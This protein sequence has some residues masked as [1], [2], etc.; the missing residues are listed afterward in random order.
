MVQL[1]SLFAILRRR[2]KW[3]GFLKKGRL[4]TRPLLVEKWI[5]ACFSYAALPWALPWAALPKNFLSLNVRNSRSVR[6]WNITALT[7]RLRRCSR[8]GG[9]REVRRVGLSFPFDS[10][11]ETLRLLFSPLWRCGPT[12]A[13]AS[14]F[15][16]FLDHTRRRITVGRAPL[17]EWSTRRRD[18]YLT[19]HNTQHRQTS[20]PHG[21][22][23]IH[24][25]SR[26]AAI[27]LRLRPRGY[28]DRQRYCILYTKLN[29]YFQF[30]VW[31]D[32][33]R[34]QCLLPTSAAPPMIMPRP[35]MNV[36]NNS[37][38]PQMA[39]INTSR[40]IPSWHTSR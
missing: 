38:T 9:D 5:K 36:R 19:T 24:N 32:V 3:V 16:R 12:R 8:E 18:L 30:T 4:S 23:R 39:V 6:C 37:L 31:T 27:D 2:L 15:L 22:I 13:L 17:D 28:W 21:G 40:S 25:L 29:L 34:L 1:Q 20:M 11:S 7:S 33:S 26:R 14:W 10:Q 35:T